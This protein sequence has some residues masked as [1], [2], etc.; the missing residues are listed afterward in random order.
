MGEDTRGSKYELEDRLAK[1][2]EEGYPSNDDAK[3]D[4]IGL[5]ETPWGQKISRSLKGLF[6]FRRGKG[7]VKSDNKRK[8]RFTAQKRFTAP[9][10][11][12]A[13]KTTI[14]Q[15]QI[16]SMNDVDDTVRRR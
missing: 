11:T 1:I 12:I 13:P 6:S 8:R 15:E 4:D 3:I 16:N 7:T 5:E 14:V 9:K 2:M 10:K